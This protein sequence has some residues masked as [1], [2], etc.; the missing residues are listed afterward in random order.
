MIKIGMTKHEKNGSLTG[1]QRITSRINT[2]VAS[3]NRKFVRLYPEP[4]REATLVQHAFRIEQLI[5]AELV[6]CRKTLPCKACCCNHRE[7]F[8]TSF[9][10]A[11]AVI[12]KYTAY[13]N[14][15]PYVNPGNN[16]WQISV[17]HWK[18]RDD[19]CEPIASIPTSSMR[20]EHSTVEGLEN[21]FDVDV[22]FS[23]G[24]V[25]TEDFVIRGPDS[26]NYIC[27]IDRYATSCQEAHSDDTTISCNMTRPGLRIYRVPAPN[28]PTEGNI[29]KEEKKEDSF[30]TAITTASDTDSDERNLASTRKA[31]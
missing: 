6:A 1:I 21:S 19:V 17:P 16:I 14:T 25:H 15:K 28:A 8:Q 5:A 12:E 23:K 9:E 26:N 18:K 24:S 20:T 27:G 4:G 11:V 29:K 13:A 22:A 30:Y 10:H 7:W 2:Q 31:P 3:C